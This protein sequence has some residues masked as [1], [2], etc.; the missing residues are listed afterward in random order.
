MTVRGFTL[1]GLV[2]LCAMVGVL[3]FGS[4][5]ALAAGAP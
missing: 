4:T 3:V 1:A 5:V 2:S